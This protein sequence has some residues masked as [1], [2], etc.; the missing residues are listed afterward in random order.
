MRVTFLLELIAALLMPSCTLLSPRPIAPS[1]DVTGFWE[2]R[3]IQICS[4]R[5]SQCGGMVRISLAMIQD[6]S[7]VSGMYECATGSVTCRNLDSQGHIAV[8]VVRGK[9]VSLRITFEDVSSCIFNGMFSDVAGG[10]AYI[11]MQGGGTIDRGFWQVRRAYGPSPP[12]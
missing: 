8:G 11:C 10:G 12:A 7:D 4:G 9:G 5:L 3:S 2:G 6:Q 1:V